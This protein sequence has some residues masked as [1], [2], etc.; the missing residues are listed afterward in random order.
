MEQMFQRQAKSL[1][2]LVR[3]CAPLYKYYN[4][5][6]KYEEERADNR[7]IETDVCNERDGLPL[8]FSEHS[9]K[10]GCLDFDGFGDVN[11]GNGGYSRSLFFQSSHQSGDLSDHFRAGCMGS[12]LMVTIGSLLV[13]G[14][15]RQ[16]RHNRHM[17]M[18]KRF[19]PELPSSACFHFRR[20]LYALKRWFV[21][22]LWVISGE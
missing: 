4:V 21:I 17:V 6:G 10:P 5:L 16:A 2:A 9:L 18:V 11:S 12:K 8:G 7:E 22:S 3:R 13:P 20:F 19:H 15:D 1:Y 14:N